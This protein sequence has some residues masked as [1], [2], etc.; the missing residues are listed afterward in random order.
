M[1]LEFIGLYLGDYEDWEWDDEYRNFF[2]FK[3]SDILLSMSPDFPKE[4]V[5]CFT[6]NMNDDCHFEIH[7]EEGKQL[8]SA[9]FIIEKAMLIN[10]GVKL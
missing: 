6:I 4:I 10:E 8:F 3:A 7:S 5:S 2:Q 9:K 1:R